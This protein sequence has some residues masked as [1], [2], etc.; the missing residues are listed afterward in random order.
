MKKSGQLLIS[1]LLR[2]ESGQSGVFAAVFLA[3]AAIGFVAFALDTGMLFRESR[4]AQ[5]AAQA[6]AVAAAEQ[7]GYG[8]SSSQQQAVANAM[9]KLNG[10]D[11]TLATNPAT[12]TL[13]TP[14][15]GNFQGAYIQA[16][17][18]MPIHTYFLGAFSKA[19]STVPVSA[20]AIAGGGVTD[21]TCICV[22]GN[23]S[24]SGGS[25]LTANGCGIFDNSSASGSISVSGG[26]TINA[27][28]LAG[29]S[30]G[31][32]SPPSSG[33]FGS[34]DTINVQDIEEG[35]TASCTPTLPLAPSYNLSS[36]IA[37]DPGNGWKSPGT[38]TEG[39]SIAGGT[40]CYSNGLTVGGN[41]MSD[42]LTSGIYVIRGGVLHFTGNPNLGGNGIF[43]YLTNGA[44]LAI[45]G[46]AKVNL[47]SGGATESGGGTAPSLGSYNGILF[48]Q[49]PSDTAAMTISGGG[50]GYINGGVIAT[51]SSL[52]LSG[53][54]SA[55]G[56][57]G[58]FSVKNMTVTGG[59]VGATVGTNQGTMTIYN[60]NPM[61]V[62]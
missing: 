5:S 61:L 31:W 33:I 60:G 28:S 1:R 36:C 29:A 50:G 46:G 26:S 25:T 54:S 59:S 57:Q 13:S 56:V 58:G 16:T 8:Q 21:P 34:G 22:S 38:L 35:D 14:T 53:G 17:V 15:N 12:V 62:Q 32:D 2:D 48:Y 18:T 24:V 55:T 41:G 42:T 40:V 9:A 19:L 6:A 23:F 39:P 44:S 3:L 47:V 49:D 30:T 52:T 37:T 27:K 11:T 45:D 4:M 51:E 7:A 43:F 20:T 10:F